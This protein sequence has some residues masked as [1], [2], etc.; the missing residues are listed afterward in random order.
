MRALLIDIGGVFYRDWPDQGFWGQWADRTGLTQ[1]QLERLLDGDPEFKR[2][3]VGEISAQE[4]VERVSARIGLAPGILR[5]LREA[6]FLSE[7]NQEM[8]DF[9][10]DLRGRG[11]T[12]FALT[13]STGSAD[14]ILARPLLA[15]L[16]EQVIS[17]RDVGA[18]KPDPRIFQAAL[19][20]LEYAAED[21][22]FVDDVLRH[23]EAA[24]G[25]GFQTVHFRSTAEAIHA[26]AA[27]IDG[28]SPTA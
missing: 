13:N 8:A 5:A 28:G 27:L 21:V 17:S 23:V 22:V 6:A 2:A 7:P 9:V 18:T 26:I 19:D 1:D 24:R 12:V 11:A 4:A 20:R 14:D 16:F 10:R 3:S 15:G 25:L